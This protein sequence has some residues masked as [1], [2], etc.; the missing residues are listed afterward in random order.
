M[1]FVATLSKN[2]KK[3]WTERNIINKLEAPKNSWS[4]NEQNSKKRGEPEDGLL[5]E[6]KKVW[7]RKRAAMILN[8]VTIIVA[9]LNDHLNLHRCCS[10]C[11]TSISKRKLL[12]LAIEL[13]QRKFIREN[14][15]V[16][17]CTIKVVKFEKI[18]S[19]TCHLL[20]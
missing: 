9:F 6:K 18:I 2:P 3:K 4:K 7:S 14:K 8:K 20:T 17:G 10:T 12:D 11:T 16:F 13:C 5:E 1:F 19:T 15:R